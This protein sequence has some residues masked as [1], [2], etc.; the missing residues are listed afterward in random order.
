MTSTQILER[1]QKGEA[2]AL[3]ELF[4]GFEKPLKSYLYRL[5]TNRHD[6]ED[7][8]HNTFLKVFDKIDTFKGDATQFK[9]WVFSIATSISLNHLN[10]EKKWAVSAQDDCRDDLQDNDAAKAGPFFGRVMQQPDV[11]FDIKEHIDFCFTCISKTL[12][13]KQQLTLLLKEIYAFKVQE[14]AEIIKATIGQ[15]KHHL[16][17]ARQTM[18]NIYDKRCALVNKNGACHQCSEL[19]GICNPKSDVQQELMKVKL[20]RESELQN[21]DKLFDLRTELINQIDPLNNNGTDLHDGLMQ[22]LKMVNNLNHQAAP[23][24]Q[25]D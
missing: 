1:A 9:S 21:A 24:D 25:T 11:Q 12:P 23:D 14:I 10:R 7:F 3:K 18:T 2:E 22:H 16:L 4:S 6:T 19:Q 17:D 20:V 5:H 8:Y 15:V 13:I